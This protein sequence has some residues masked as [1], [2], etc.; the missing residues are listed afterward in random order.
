MEKKHKLLTFYLKCLVISLPVLLLVAFY[1]YKDPFMVLRSYTDYD[2]S[3]VVQDEGA[4]AWEKYKQ[5]RRRCHYDSYV[6][7]TSCTKAFP[8]SIWQHYITGRPFR[9]F[10]NAEGLG[11]VSLKLEALEEQPG[12]KI[13]NLLL[14]VERS[15]FE[16]ESAQ[17]GIMHLMPPEVTGKSWASYQTEF[18]QSF[19]YP[20]F[21]VPYL[22]YAFT[23]YRDP[24]ASGVFYDDLPSRDRVTNEALLPE[25]AEIKRLGEHYWQQGEWNS[26]T[27][28]PRETSLAPRVLGERQIRM[29]ADLQNFCERHHT[30][31]T[32]VIGPNYQRERFNPDDLDILLHIFGP[33]CVYDYSHDDRFID[34]HDYYD[35][36][37][38]RARMGEAIMKE[39]YG[40][41]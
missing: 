29:L 13:E 19:F 30:N 18:L 21:L 11:D 12:Q 10:S 27:R 7:G 14:V 9:F 34:F 20:K 28:K 25:E 38:Y 41:R 40:K 23:G 31:L 26:E 4:V 39:I 15:F 32:M 5:Q 8:C 3:W 22:K 2:H 16:K 33:Q 6:M 17:G 1:A 24:K 36:S 37:H 35:M